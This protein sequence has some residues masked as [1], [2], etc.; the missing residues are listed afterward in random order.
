M[1]VTDC[2]Y[3]HALVL[4]SNKQIELYDQKMVTL[5]GISSRNVIGLHMC[6]V[7]ISQF[8]RSEHAQMYLDQENKRK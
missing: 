3:R 6:S 8:T 4:L 7:I 1:S 5:N 2:I